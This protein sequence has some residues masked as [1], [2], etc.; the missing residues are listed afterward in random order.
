[1][2]RGYE[3]G[4]ERGNFQEQ[5]YISKQ[6]VAQIQDL[7]L[8]IDTMC[9]VL[10]LAEKYALGY[11]EKYGAYNMSSAKGEDLLRL[12]VREIEIFRLSYEDYVEEYKEYKF[13]RNLSKGQ[14][15]KD[16]ENWAKVAHEE[17]IIYYNAL[18]NIINGNYNF[19]LKDEIKKLKAKKKQT[20]YKEGEKAK[21]LQNHVPV[22]SYNT[23]QLAKN[24]EE[25]YLKNKNYTPKVKL[26]QKSN[27]EMLNKLSKDTHN[28]NDDDSDEDGDVD[29]K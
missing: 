18:A 10:T 16:I 22:I 24:T 17:S 11:N 26:N 27:Q 12:F 7:E 29:M 4:K 21:N 6:E 5:Q 1:M 15:L 25:N 2:N 9:R 14:I 19:S 28:K 20:P 23:R 8:S 3:R 13:P